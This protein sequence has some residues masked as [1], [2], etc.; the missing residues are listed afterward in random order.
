MKNNFLATVLAT[1]FAFVNPLHAQN[2]KSESMSFGNCLQ[3][4]RN[5]SAELATA[6]ENIVE[7]NDLRMVR[8]NT[9]DGSVLV[10]CSRPDNKM[11][12]TIS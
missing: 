6:P 1:A 10:T 7:T 5:V 9:S 8:F 4:I 11:V 3:L 12:L 2:S